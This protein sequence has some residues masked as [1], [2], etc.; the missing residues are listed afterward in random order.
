ML[1]SVNLMNPQ[2]PAPGDTLLE[3]KLIGFAEVP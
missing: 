1:E 3:V 2:S